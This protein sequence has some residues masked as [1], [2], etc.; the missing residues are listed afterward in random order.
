MQSALWHTEIG[1][2]WSDKYELRVGCSVTTL[3]PLCPSSSNLNYVLANK[4]RADT[5]KT[6]IYE[7][8]YFLS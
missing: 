2:V 4:P 3:G 5:Q 6:V 1:R 8:R 7:T